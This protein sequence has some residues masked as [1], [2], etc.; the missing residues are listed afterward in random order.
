M[1]NQSIYFFL[2]DIIPITAF[3]IDKNDDLKAQGMYTTKYTAPI[4]FS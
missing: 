3:L 1:S 2:T 4:L